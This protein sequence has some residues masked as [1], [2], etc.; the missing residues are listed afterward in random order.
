MVRT[1]REMTGVYGPVLLT[2]YPAPEGFI[3]RYVLCLTPIVLVVISLIVLTFML[4]IVNSFLPALG[5][6]R[7]M[8]VPD[9]PV[10]IDIC[11]LLISPVGIFLFFIYLG[12]VLHRAE[13][14]AGATLTLL[15]SLA[16][17]WF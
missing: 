16:G 9:L 4:N 15:L 8:I 14:W 1:E 13:L 5:N 2:T 11:A 10:I 17:R 7:G 6:S 3:N 12:D